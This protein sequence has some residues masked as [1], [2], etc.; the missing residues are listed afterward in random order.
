MVHVS[1]D[2]YMNPERRRTV[3][4]EPEGRISLPAELFTAFFSEN[5]TG[6]VNGSIVSNK[7]VIKD[8]CISHSPLI[9]CEWSLL[10]LY[11]IFE[12]NSI[13]Q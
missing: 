12:N 1:P 13:V 8:K 9:A 7:E 3:L 11:N 10:Y 4:R 5:I 2:D 6:V